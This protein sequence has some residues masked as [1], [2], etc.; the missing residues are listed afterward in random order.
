MKG[1]I[2][3]PKRFEGSFVCDR[4]NILL[5]GLANDLG[6][7]LVYSDALDESDIYGDIILSLKTPQGADIIKGNDK[8][9]KTLMSLPEDIKVITYFS[10]IHMIR[11]KLENE[12]QKAML[13][14]LA[15]SNIILTAYWY[16]FCERFPYFTHKTIHFP[17]FYAPEHRYDMKPNPEALLK[18]LTCGVSNKLYD[19]RK[20]L[21]DHES[22]CKTGLIAYLP[23]P[24][25]SKDV[26]TTAKYKVKDAYAEELHKY[27]C[28]FADC[29]HMQYVVGKYFEIPAAGSLLLARYAKDL[30][31]LGFK[32]GVNYIKVNSN[33]IVDYI[34]DI[35]NNPSKYEHIRQ[36][37]WE[38]VHNKFSL[39]NRLAQLKSII[40]NI[41][42]S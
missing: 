13:P 42:K 31:K 41:E 15:R 12:Y 24:G 29:T 30:P 36:A 20:Y 37:G 2:H 17:H 26:K 25:Y 3:M 38:F 39:S 18:C 6:W 33:N 34:Y 10:D 4:Y 22:T 14:V 5:D 32:D 9:W 7:K 35:L 1:T 23:H 16:P 19:L 28:G 40:K 27:Y 21:I 8:S 11:P